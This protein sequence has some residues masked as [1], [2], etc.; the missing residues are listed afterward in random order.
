MSEDSKPAGL[1]TGSEGGP[2]PTP[3][4]LLKSSAKETAALARRAAELALGARKALAAAEAGRNVTLEAGA[5]VSAAL[6]AADELVK[7]ETA[8]LVGRVGKALA[9][10]QSAGMKS[11]ENEVMRMLSKLDERLRSTGF[12][13]S[14]HY[15]DVGCGVF[16]LH[17]DLTSKGMAASLAY[18]PGIEKLAALADPTL[19]SLAKA[20]AE[21]AADLDKGLLP[22][23]EF[24]PLLKAA[25][26]LA[27]ITRPGTGP[28]GLPGTAPVGPLPILDVLATLSFLVQSDRFRR[29]PVRQTFLPFGQ[30][31]LSYQLFRLASRR[32]GDEELAMGIATRED[33]KKQA[34]LWVPRNLKGE[35]N[36]YSTLE[37]R[38]VLTHGDLPA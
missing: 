7:P 34:S 3:A 10:L 12:S 14:G 21:A 28:E 6:K 18:G 35:G 25:Y 23:D 9:E 17:F 27:P 32:I 4:E 13:L 20:V 19:D 11:A 15:P 8:T 2:V 29:N 16:S 37:F 26:R 38:R 1:G 30:V 33:V 5:A 31:R 22:S 24:L 36:H